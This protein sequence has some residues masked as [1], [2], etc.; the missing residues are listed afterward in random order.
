MYNTHSH[1]ISIIALYIHFAMVTTR[2]EA[3]RR[4]LWGKLPVLPTH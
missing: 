2:K 3:S 4:W 1:P